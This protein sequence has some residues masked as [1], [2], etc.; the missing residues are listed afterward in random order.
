MRPRATHNLKIAETSSPR[1]ED[2]IISQAK[3][4][5]DLQEYRQTE[6]LLAYAKTHYPTNTRVQELEKYYGE[7]GSDTPKRPKRTR[8]MGRVLMPRWNSGHRVTMLSVRRT[9]IRVVN[10]WLSLCCDWSNCFINDMRNQS[11][12]TFFLLMISLML[13][14]CSI[15]N[16]ATYVSPEQ[17]RT[18]P[19]EED[20]QENE[21]LVI[22]YHDVEDHNPNQAYL[23]VSTE[24][25][26]QQF[27]WLHE[28]N[29][30]PVSVEQVLDARDGKSVLPKQAVM[31]TFDDG[32]Y[33][34]IQPRWS[35]QPFWQRRRKL[36]PNQV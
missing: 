4:A 26:R 16:P 19:Q 34:G 23:S 35:E 24:H 6:E 2:V 28:N 8:A 14:S 22:A 18:P 9:S 13:A 31:L 7:S 11:V 12:F 1:Q 25:L 20:W 33:Y 36:I 17:R 30:V 21:L 15:S 32:Y 5:L 3:T 27:S 10:T 29:Y